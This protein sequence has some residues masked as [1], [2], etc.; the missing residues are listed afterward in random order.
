MVR[1]GF[2]A[3]VVAMGAVG[4]AFDD[5]AIGPL[6]IV[7][8]AATTDVAPNPD[9]D[10]VADAAPAEPAQPA[11]ALADAVAADGAAVCESDPGQPPLAAVRRL[12]TT[13]EEVRILVYGQAISD[14]GW[15]QQVRDWLRAQYP[16]GNLVMEDHARTGCSA[17]CLIGREAWVSDG[18]AVNRVP[19]DVLAWRPD[20]II[21]AAY[22]RH[23]DYEDLVAAFKDG[24]PAFD[25]HP[26]ATAHCQAD[27]RHAEYRGAEVLLQTY[28]RPR[29]LDDATPLPMLPPIPD[30][31]WDR[32]MSTVWIPAVAAR[33]GAQVAPIWVLWSDYLRAHAAPAADFL[34]DDG[35]HLNARG[36]DLM[37]RLT[38][39]SLCYQ[40]PAR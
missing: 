22:G 14:L 15:W 13:G 8:D 1:G 37:A 24:C 10:P 33:R 28:H 38:E 12:A 5:R 20:L 7:V 35:E 3:G 26:A 11:D 31:Q 18:A 2:W 4:C 23:D 6:P 34:S 27:E 36:N 17:Q 25:G 40:P 21:F 32:W 39:R 19:A 30:G 29:T 9:T 16:K